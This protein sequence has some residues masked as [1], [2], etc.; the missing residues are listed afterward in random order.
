[1]VEIQADFE[2]CRMEQYLFSFG[3]FNVWAALFYC[4]PIECE[5]L[6]ARRMAEVANKSSLHGPLLSQT[7][8]TRLISILQSGC[9]G[10]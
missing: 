8:A 3:L 6:K 2:Q 4:E 10:K 1:M 7:S 9:Q 5:E